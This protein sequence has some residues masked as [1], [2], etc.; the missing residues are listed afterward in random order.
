MSNLF[1][2]LLTELNVS[3]YSMHATII[4]QNINYIFRVMIP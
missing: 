2:S 3:N 4:F 1:T